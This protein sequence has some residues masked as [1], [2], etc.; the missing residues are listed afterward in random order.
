MGVGVALGDGKKEWAGCVWVCVCVRID[1]ECTQLSFQYSVCVCSFLRAVSCVWLLPQLH[2]MGS[3]THHRV[4]LSLCLIHSLNLQ[5]FGD[6][7]CKPIQQ[8]DGGADK[9][10]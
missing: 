6:L 9:K 4:P 7:Q 10:K 2:L 8:K 1:T 5:P 3:S